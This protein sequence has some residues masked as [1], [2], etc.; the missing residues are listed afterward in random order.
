M[1]LKSH[2]QISFYTITLFFFSYFSWSS[3][4]S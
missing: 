1:G 4:R 2:L 3:P